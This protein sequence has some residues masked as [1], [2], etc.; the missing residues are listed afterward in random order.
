MS[1]GISKYPSMP[2]KILPGLN[3]TKTCLRVDRVYQVSNDLQ[4]NDNGLA[5]LRSKAVVGNLHKRSPAYR[6]LTPPKRT[7]RFRVEFRK[8]QTATLTTERDGP[9]LR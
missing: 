7:G 1:A 4:E 5:A 2:S 8:G 9:S 6:R 3:D